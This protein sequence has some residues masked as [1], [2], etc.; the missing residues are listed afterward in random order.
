M[1]NLLKVVVDE[2]AFMEVLDKGLEV[3]VVIMDRVEELVESFN[4]FDVGVPEVLFQ[5]DHIYVVLNPP[6]KH[7]WILQVGEIKQD[8]LILLLIIVNHAS[9]GYID[10]LTDSKALGLLLLSVLS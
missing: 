8:L 1:E 9:C 7:I 3:S 2:V 10:L 6:F 5:L 4:D